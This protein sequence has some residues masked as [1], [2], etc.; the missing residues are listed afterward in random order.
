M[1]RLLI[2]L[3]LLVT[4][5]SPVLAMEPMSKDELKETTAQI[6]ATAGQGPFVYSTA[7]FIIA[8]LVID[9]IESNKHV[10]NLTTGIAPVG[11]AQEAIT[12]VREVVGIYGDARGLASGITL[13]FF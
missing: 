7:R 12:P 6:A 10:D 5:G 4:L 11:V 2:A 1:K 9:G 3:V 8:D 13:G